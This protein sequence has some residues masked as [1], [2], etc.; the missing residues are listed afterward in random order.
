MKLLFFACQASSSVLFCYYDNTAQYRPN[1]GKFYPEDIDADLCTHIGKWFL[2]LLFNF[3][4]RRMGIWAPKK[5]FK[6]FSAARLRPELDGEWGLGPTEW[7]DLDEEWMT[8]LYSRVNN[9][10]KVNPNLKTILSV[11]NSNLWTE[12]ADSGPAVRSFIINS[13]KYCRDNGFD[14]IE[15][16]WRYPAQCNPVQ[17]SPETDKYVFQARVTLIWSN[18][19]GIRL[20]KSYELCS[21]CT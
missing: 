15:L 18:L 12:M 8:G 20:E 5:S 16:D 17:C 14:G 2:R 7:N 10:K 21:Y 9:L 11:Q 19:I 1:L 4:Q 13:L 3:F 6:V